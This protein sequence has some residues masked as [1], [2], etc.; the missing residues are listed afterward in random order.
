LGG[1]TTV[2]ASNGVASFAGLSVN[3]PGVGD[4]MTASNA[5]LVTTSTAFTVVA[6]KAT[7]LAVTTQPASS[8][9]A[10]QGFGLTVS[11]KDSNGFVLVVKAEDANGNVNPTFTGSVDVALAS[12]PGSS[13][14]GGTLSVSASAGI[15]TFSGLTLNVAAGGY[16]LQITNTGLTPV[17]TS[18]VNVT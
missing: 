16:T 17:T 3:Q 9:T 1:T 4:K 5:G 7:Q 15:A 14:L 10:G 11:A 8:V 6:G 12:N 2:T 13:T 18:A